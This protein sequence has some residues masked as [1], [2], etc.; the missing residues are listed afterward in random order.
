VYASKAGHALIDRELY[1][2]KGWID[3]PDRCWAA[4]SDLTSYPMKGAFSLAA[5]LQQP[6]RTTETSEAL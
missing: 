1:L 4:G 2:P 6:H 3:D 5:G